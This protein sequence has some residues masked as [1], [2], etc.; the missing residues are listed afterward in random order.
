MT[1]EQALGVVLLG[2]TGS[3]G[4]SAIE[5]LRHHPQRF[6]LVALAARGGN[7]EVLLE[8][9]REFE[10]ELVAVIEPSAADWLRG[11]LPSTTRLVVGRE[12]LLE[13]ATAPQ[14]QRVLA[15]MVGAAGLP[16][17]HA[18]V[19]ARKTVALANK[20]ALVVGGRVLTELAAR[21]GVD[22]LPVDSEHAALHQALRCGRP[23]EVAR[24]VLTA[25]GGPSGIVRSRPGIRFGPRTPSAT[26][27]GRWARR[28]PSTRP[29]WSTRRSS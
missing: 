6:R 8:Q 27:R 18:A 17:V 28:S 22:L 24:L 5:V 9:A 23:S 12:G 14:A 10:P 16:A 21:R 15:A 3:I 25:S 13:A 20:E 26:R 11:R 7:A 1:S 4:R 19:D 29:R 2:S